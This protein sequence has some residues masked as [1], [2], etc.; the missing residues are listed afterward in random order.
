[1]YYCPS[2]LKSLKVCF[3]LWMSVL[4]SP[5]D[6]LAI[7]ELVKCWYQSRMTLEQLHEGICSFNVYK[8]WPEGEGITWI[9]ERV[10]KFVRSPPAKSKIMVQEHKHISSQLFVFDTL[11]RKTE[12]EG[13]HQFNNIKE[14]S[15]LFL[16]Y[17]NCLVSSGK[18]HPDP[19][20]SGEIRESKI[21]LS[22]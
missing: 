7:G 15:F 10:S 9:V 19:W 21:F 11:N 8:F 14:C 18:S 20:F 1:M 4:S 13:S 2:E 12:Q 6:L 3:I 22:T 5:R 17:I 16:F